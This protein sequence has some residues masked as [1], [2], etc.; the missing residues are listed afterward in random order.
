M[1]M[2]NYVEEIFGSK[3]KVKIIRTMFRYPTKTFTGR[4]LANLT[5]GV[6][7][8]A[9]ADSIKDLIDVSLIKIE[10]HGTSNLLTLNKESYLFK[11]LKD[12]FQ[13]E[14]DT[15][16]SLKEQILTNLSDIKMVVLFGSVAKKQEEANSDVDLLIVAKNKKLVKKVINENQDKILKIFGNLISPIIVDENEFKKMKNKP[17]AKTLVKHYELLKGKDLIRGVWLK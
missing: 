4:E 3:V 1:L 11:M 13:A 2:H 12:F 9:V 17:F 15:I 7:H 5:K 16:S 14:E 6:S 8:M 10:H